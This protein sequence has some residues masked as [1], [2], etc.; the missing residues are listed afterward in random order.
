MFVPFCQFFFGIAAT[1]IFIFFALFTFSAGEINSIV[2]PNVPGG[3]A[4]TFVLNDNLRYSILGQL[5][6]Y[7]W[8]TAFLIAIGQMINAIA[9]SL[10]YFTRKDKKSSLKC[11]T[12]KGICWC[13]RYHLGTLLFGAFII[14]VC[15]IIQVILMYLQ[16]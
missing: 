10:W 15:K 6:V 7:F 1:A 3:I 8:I 5:F 9:V 14:A 11:T 13:F 2:V 12:C 16:K 4:R